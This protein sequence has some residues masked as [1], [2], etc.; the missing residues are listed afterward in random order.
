MHTIDSVDAL[1]VPTNVA[2][3]LLQPINTE[4]QQIRI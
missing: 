2:L 4:S 1:I 3:A